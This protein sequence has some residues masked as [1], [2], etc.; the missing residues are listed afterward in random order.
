MK[1]LVEKKISKA[2]SASKIIEFYRAAFYVQL[3][4]EVLKTQKSFS[5]VP[6]PKTPDEAF[7][8]L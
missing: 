3:L 2:S 7:P 8:N 1:D 4:Y 6:V 5:D